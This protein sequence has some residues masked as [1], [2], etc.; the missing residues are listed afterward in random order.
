MIN[1]NLPENLFDPG[2][3]GIGDEYLAEIVFAYQPDKL[4]Y[5][6]IVQLVEDIVEQQDGLEAFDLP[7]VIELCQF[8][9]HYVRFL[10]TLGTKFL[11]RI[12]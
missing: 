7:G 8:D 9:G 11:Q 4:V 6:L 1:I 12:A 5:P 3:L 10:L 2:A